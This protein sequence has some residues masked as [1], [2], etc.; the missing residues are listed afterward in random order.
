L[1]FVEPPPMPTIDDLKLLLEYPSEKLSI[2]YK[3]WLDLTDNA[4]KANLAKAAIALANE[5]GGIIVLGMRED[6]VRGGALGS[7]PP[8]AGL[9]RY[10]Q[11]NINAAIE[12]F[13]D[14]AFH[15]TLMFAEHP[16]TR[17]EHAFVIVPGGMTVPVMS[18]RGADGQIQ[19]QRCYVRKPGPRSEEPYTSAEW[20]GI[21]ERCLQ[22]RRQTMLEAIRVIVQ[23]HADASAAAEDGDRLLQYADAARDR[24]TELIRELPRDDIARMPAGHYELAFQLE[25]VPPTPSLNELLRRMQ[26]ASL[27]SIRDGGLSCC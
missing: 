18:T 9:A 8:L 15:C 27:S 7:Q 4:A 21:F 11:D 12:R 14:P 26:D 1:I 24:W 5:G 3:S 10:S 20:R 13:A 23:G 22:A 25:D 17:T 2:E 19:A 6:A 16:L